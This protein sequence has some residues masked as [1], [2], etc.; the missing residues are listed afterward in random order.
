M[1]KGHLPAGFRRMMRRE[2][3]QIADRPAL[4]LML[5]PLPLLMFITLAYM[6]QAGLPTSLPVAVVDLDGSYMSRQVTRMVDATPEVDVTLRLSSLTQAKEALVARRAY[7]VLYIPQNMAR[8]LQ[9]GYR[10]DLVIFINNQLYTTGSIAKRAIGGALSTFNAGVSVQTRMARGSDR[11]SAMA[12]ANP[13][14]LQTNALFNP[15]LDYIQF[16][17]ASIM[18]ALLQVFISVSTAL[19]FSRDHHNEAGLAR[20]LRLG[21]TPLRMIAGKMAPYTIIWCFMMLFTDA[22]LFGV[23]DAAFNGSILLHCLYSL[24]FVLACQFLGATSALLSRD[25]V[26]TL[27]FAGLLTAPAFGFAGISY[28]RMMMSGFAQGWG[29]IIPLT[30]YLELR[31][32]QV[33]RGTPILTSLPTM[34]WALAVAAGWGGIL[35]L[36]IWIIPRKKAKQK[37]ASA[38]ED[39]STPAGQGAAS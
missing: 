25:A 13:I 39:T 19:S 36:L 34:G 31:T 17:L 27:G 8:D 30:P 29:A 6:F 37:L 3:R 38:Q 1:W 2:M 11:D 20:A 26:A 12:A 33:L 18:P 15:T 4:A 24:V 32:D 9:R 7:A 28:P 22:I 23:F 21:R 5:G 10:P 16:L 14:P 35:L